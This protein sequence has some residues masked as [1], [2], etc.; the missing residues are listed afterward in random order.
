MIRPPLSMTKVVSAAPETTR[1]VAFWILSDW[2]VKVPEPS[3]VAAV[4]LTL[5]A[6]VQ[7]AAEVSIA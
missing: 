1:A 4:S 5:V 7:E 3:A 2:T 6:D